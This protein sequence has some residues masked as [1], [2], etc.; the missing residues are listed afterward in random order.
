MMT[1]HGQGA[2]PKQMSLTIV[3]S[4]GDCLNSCRAA[5]FSRTLGETHRLDEREDALFGMI[6]FVILLAVGNQSKVCLPNPLLRQCRQSSFLA[7]CSASKMPSS[8]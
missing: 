6:G 3:V 4:A 1:S 8:S 5:L 2:Q 7:R